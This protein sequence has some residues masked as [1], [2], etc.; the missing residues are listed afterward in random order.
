MPSPANLTA[1]HDGIIDSI[2]VRQGTGMVKAGEEVKS[3]DILISGKVEL[4]ADDGTIKGTRYCKADGAVYLI[5]K[6]PIYENQ[7][8][9]YLAKEYTGNYTTKFDIYLNQRLLKIPHLKIPYIKYDCIT[10]NIEHPI[11]NLLSL[12]LTIKKNDYR[13]YY[14]TR[15]K[16]TVSETEKLLKEKLDKIILSLEEKGVQIIEKNVKINTNSVALSMT[17]TLTLRTLCQEFQ[18]LEEFQ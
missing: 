9:E 7:S 2:V 15:K 18:T 13:E 11:I 16:Y 1:D 17:G 5:Y 12:P 14:V 4:P 8:F 3:G 6:Y 10:Q